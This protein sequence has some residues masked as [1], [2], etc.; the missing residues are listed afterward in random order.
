MNSLDRLQLSY[1]SL[2]RQKLR[3][4]LTIIALGI[5]IASV[6]IILSAGN[7][8]ESMIVGELDVYSPNSLNI[9]VRIPGKGETGSATGFAS[10]ITITTLK[11]TDTEA[12]GRLP[13]VDAIYDYV[14]GQEV[15]KYQGENKTVILFGYGADAV[16]V[17]KL[18]IAEGRFYD[19]S[20]ED[21][22][23][24]VLVLGH[25]VKKD[26]FGED[27]AVGKNVYMRGKS[28]KVVGVM[29]ERGATFGFDYDALVYI[30]TKTLQKRLMGTDFVMGIMARVT[31]IEKIDQTKAEVEY[32]LRDRHNINDPEQDD[33]QVTTMDEIREMMDTIVGGITLLLVALVC[34]S[35]IVGGV[36]ITNIMYVTVAERTFEIGLRKAV[37]ATGKDILWQFLA[38]A[39]ILTF[40]G[41][42][43]GV[44]L[45]V[46]ISFGV[47]YGAVSYG[48]NWSFS[49][50]IFSIILSLGFST[51]VGLF[52]G[53]YP[54]K[55]AAGLDPIEALRK[56]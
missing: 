39:M 51:F 22:L 48:L 13:N 36:G 16:K 14:T 30:P 9:E 31:D 4:V 10:G 46:I 20:E 7:G 8:L 25:A 6:V 27:S 5:G 15:I 43:V 1:T 56:E 45:G 18:D 24:Q 52:F 41:G 38:E 26:L 55:K 2:I 53:I 23:S 33:F 17:E 49:I 44:I 50:S 11:N 37:G 19:K 47:Y 3:T 54:A 42:V 29:V 21:S 28:F 34:I 40:F 12:I 32:L 35:L